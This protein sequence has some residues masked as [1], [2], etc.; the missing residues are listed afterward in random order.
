MRTS[1]V[2]EVDPVADHAHRMLQRFEAMAMDAL[3]F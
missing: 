1:V 3:F 2:V